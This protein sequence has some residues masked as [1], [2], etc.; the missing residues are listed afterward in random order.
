ML[1]DIIAKAKKII[2]TPKEFFQGAKK[3]TGIK[4][5]LSFFAILSL[6]NAILSVVVFFVTNT[7]NLSKTSVSSSF[8]GPSL[9]IGYLINLGI[10]FVYAGILHLW[11]KL[12][13]GSAKFEKTY[14]LYVYSQTLKLLIGWIPVVSIFGWF[15]SFYLL[16]IGTQEFHK[17]SKKKTI[18]MYIIPAVVLTI[19]GFVV[20]FLVSQYLIANPNV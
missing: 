14:Q 16:I 7:N 11:I 17:I 8:F 19:L 10:S 15:Y 3:E 9:V 1:K 2:L 20:A 4:T 6:F 5:A 12:F 18:V 13:K